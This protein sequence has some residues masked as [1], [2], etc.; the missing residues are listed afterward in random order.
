MGIDFRFN[1]VFD[2]MTDLS[3]TKVIKRLLQRDGGV[4][5]KLGESFNP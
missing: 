1:R 5:R 3:V 4:N 2:E